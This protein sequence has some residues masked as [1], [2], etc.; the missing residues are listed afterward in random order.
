M[1]ITVSKNL[2]IG[3]LSSAIDVN[4]G[5]LGY[6]RVTNNS[7]GEY[8]FLRVDCLKG[9]FPNFLNKTTVL[10]SLQPSFKNDCPSDDGIQVDC[11]SF[12]LKK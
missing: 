7:L 2:R 9:V 5:E 3:I 6:G 11:H 8:N 10:P 4:I 12:S 1:F